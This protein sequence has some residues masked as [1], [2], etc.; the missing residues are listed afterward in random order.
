M[1]S[2]LLNRKLFPR[3]AA[4]SKNG[5]V[6]LIILLATCYIL[7]NVLKVILI[8]ANDHPQTVGLIMRPYVALGNGVEWLSKPWTIITFFLVELKLFTLLT[9]ILWLY[10]FGSALQS[11]VGYREI[12]PLFLIS[13]IIGGLLFILMR[14]FFPTV[15]SELY[16]QGA[17]LGILALGSAAL[18][19]APTYRYYIS[20]NFSFPLWIGFLIFLILNVVLKFNNL[21]FYILIAGVALVAW[22]YTGML[23][24]GIRWGNNLYKIVDK[25][26]KRFD[27]DYKKAAVYDSK[28]IPHLKQSR[29][30]L[31]E[32]QIN[33][34]LEKIHQNGLSS[35]SKEEHKLLE[36]LSQE[37]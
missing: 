30:E 6:H 9:N 20:E 25:L 15:S 1:K 13:N 17:L 10:F 26:N 37:L 35:L 2:N 23:K 11:L 21:T 29:H 3:T 34:L 27:K 24:R 5:I 4:Y 31:K 32:V 33:N 8:I 36:K 22:I 16:L 14:T 18:F 19:I 12:F 28:K 7:F